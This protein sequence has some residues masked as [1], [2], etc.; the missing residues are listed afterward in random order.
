M[1]VPVAKIHERFKGEFFAQLGVTDEAPDFD[2]AQVWECDS[3]NEVDANSQLHPWLDSE[4]PDFLTQFL[5]DKKTSRWYY[6]SIGLWDRIGIGDINEEG[7]IITG[8]YEKTPVMFFSRVDEDFAKI[9][10]ADKQRR[11]TEAVTRGAMAGI[12]DDALSDIMERR[13]KIIENSIKNK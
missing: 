12:K 2:Y 10:M 6:I 8:E 13:A 4:N 7:E 9:K 1:P 5:L 3:G 11:A